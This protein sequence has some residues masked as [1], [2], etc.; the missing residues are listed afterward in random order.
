MKKIIYLFVLAFLFIACKKEYHVSGRVYN[1]ITNDGIPNVK[2]RFS[3]SEGGLPGGF[4]EVAS[5]FTDANGYYNLEYK[6]VASLVKADGDENLYMMGNFYE[7]SYT[8]TLPLDGGKNLNVDW[9][10]VPYGELDV[11]LNNINCQGANDTLKL[12]YD[13]SFIP[14]NDVQIGFLSQNT[15]CINITSSAYPYPMGER[16]YH[17]E[18]IRNGLVEAV[19][20]DTIFIQ[21]NQV[22][23]LEI[24]Y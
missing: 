8:P 22:N 14:Y 17:W 4:K 20:Y 18:I 23:T 5:T 3:A 16:Y 6:G 7:G 2:I 21:P 24:V 11:H 15:G 12:F 9:H 19:V 1:P 13:G 10:A